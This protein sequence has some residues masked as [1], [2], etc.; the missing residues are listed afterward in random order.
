VAL[1]LGQDS[2]YFG[3]AQITF[4]IKNFDKLNKE[5][6]R[7]IFLNFSKG[8]ITWAS[9]DVIVGVQKSQQAA[10]G[11]EAEFALQL[12]NTEEIFYNNRI[13]IYNLYD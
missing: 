7:Y 2:S 1:A 10:T 13:N 4:T 11:G 6:F 8:N 9:D 3:Q 12:F 5:D